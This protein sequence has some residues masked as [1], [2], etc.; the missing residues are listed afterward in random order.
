MNCDHKN[1]LLKYA[2]HYGRINDCKEVIMTNITPDYLEL[3]VD[4]KFIKINFDHTLKDSEDAHKTLV[5]M[6]RTMPKEA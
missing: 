5:K 6:I 2:I 4:K 3:E 1:A